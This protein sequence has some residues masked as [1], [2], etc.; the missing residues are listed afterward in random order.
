MRGWLHPD[1]VFPAV[2]VLC[3][4]GSLRQIAVLERAGS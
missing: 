3:L 2:L 4:I 1:A